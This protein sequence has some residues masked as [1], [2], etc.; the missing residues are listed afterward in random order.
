MKFKVLGGHWG[1]GW[2]PGDVVEM[3][4]EAAKVRLEL[5]ELEEAKDGVVVKKTEQQSAASPEVV[6]RETVEEEK[7]KRGRPKKL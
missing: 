6:S 4:L 1:E 5:G 7:P 3:D 2:L